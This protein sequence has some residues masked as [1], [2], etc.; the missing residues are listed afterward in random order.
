MRLV[1]VLVLVAVA[2]AVAAA[3]V[4]LRDDD[5]PSDRTGSLTMVGDSLNVG[6]EPYLVNE[7]PGWRIRMDDEVGRGSDDGIDA[8]AGIGAELGSVVVVSLGTN[9]PQED[10]DAFRADVREL[11]SLTGPERCVVWATIWR[12]DANAS[13]NDVLIDEAHAN[14][15]LRL[16]RWHEMVEEHPEWLIGD[17]VHGSPEGY[18]ARAEAIADV[19]RDCLPAAPQ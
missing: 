14:R 3:I 4:V 12:G 19:A 17:G 9:D 1:A 15:A 16:V 7:L 2:V 6:V 13:F 11:L 5:T 18:A 8:L 10:A